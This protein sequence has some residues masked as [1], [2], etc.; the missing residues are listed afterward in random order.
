MDHHHKWTFTSYVFE[1]SIWATESTGIMYSGL[2]TVAWLKQNFWMILLK[3]INTRQQA[4]TF[5]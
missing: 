2:F 1:V 5:V 4:H 3:N